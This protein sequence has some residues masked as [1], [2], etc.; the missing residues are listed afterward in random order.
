MIDFLPWDPEMESPATIGILGAGPLGIEAALYARFLG[1]HV[2]IFESRRVAH[3]MLDWHNRPLAHPAAELT[4]SLGLAALVAQYPEKSPLDPE[5]VLTGKE[6]AEEYLVPLA[7]TD[8]LFDDI[9]FLSPVIDVSRIQPHEPPTASGWDEYPW[10]DRCNDEFR[11]VV[12]GRH[13]G[14]WVSHVDCIIDCR[15]NQHQAKGLGPGGGQ[16]IGERELQKDFSLVGP[17]DRKF[18]PK[19]YR[20]R[21]VLVV[22]GSVHAARTM[23]EFAEWQKTSPDTDLV[24]ILPPRRPEEPEH[25]ARARAILEPQACQ[26]L[27]LIECLGVQSIEKQSQEEGGDSAWKLTLI[28]QDDSTVEICGDC[29]IRRTEF[30]R[31]TIAPSLLVENP[32]AMRRF[33]QEISA[34]STATAVEANRFD[35]WVK[36][37]I[38]PEPGYYRL[39]ADSDER[40]PGEGLPKAFE[41]LRAIFAILGGRKDLDLYAI[42]RAQGE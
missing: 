2:S 3:R 40:A 8:L 18:D 28:K 22:G 10:Q 12:Q 23:L 16:A 19:V 27:V 1:Y 15:G 21:K 20:N 41:R 38:T 9:H 34:E 29:V 13:R 25:L 30:Y 14:T 17:E 6:Y 24:W 36:D 39:N 5:R 42:M 33:W 37:V 32:D 7:K 26:R 4:T 11:I 31:E 35:Q